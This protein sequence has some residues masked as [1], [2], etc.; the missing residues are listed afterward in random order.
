MTTLKA[1]VI[2]DN[3]WLVKDNNKQV[4]AVFHDAFGVTFLHDG[5]KEKF[6]S[7]TNLKSKYKIHIDSSNTSSSD[8]EVYGY[9]TDTTPYNILW[10]LKYKVPVY[11][12]SE[13]STSFYAA[14]YYNIT[15]EE[16]ITQTILCPKLITIERKQY[17]GPYQSLTLAVKN[18]RKRNASS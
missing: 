9:P 1:K 15:V 6:N 12:T 10:N 3:C 8:N 14:G 18:L 13:K 11:T 5:T 2:N 16:G 4:G 17:T 7:L